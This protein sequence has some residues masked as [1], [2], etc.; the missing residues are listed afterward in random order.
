MAQYGERLG[1]S[2]DL[3]GETVKV[4]AQLGSAGL[5]PFLGNTKR[6][7]IERVAVTA[8]Y[9]TRGVHRGSGR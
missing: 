7:T 6:K 3:Q 5:H 4:S 9:F 2:E 1:E 8:H